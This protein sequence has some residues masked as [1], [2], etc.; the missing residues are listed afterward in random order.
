MSAKKA[1]EQLKGLPAKDLH[2]MMHKR[3]FNLATTPALAAAG[4]SG[5]QEDHGK[6]RVQPDHTTDRDGR[7]GV[8]SLLS[9]IF[10]LFTSPEGKKFLEK[11]VLSGKSD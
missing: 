9:G 5:L 8:Q 7:D 10:L 6:G 4:C 2:E 3:G 1:A 11:L